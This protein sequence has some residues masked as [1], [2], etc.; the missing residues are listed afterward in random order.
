MQAEF[1]KIN[2][3]NDI[4]S[5][6]REYLSRLSE[7]QELYLEL[8]VKKS[9]CYLI[10][11]TISTIGYAA[12]LD[13]EII[14]EFFVT[15]LFQSVREKVFKSLVDNFGIRKVWCKT[16]DPDLLSC[17]AQYAR[18]IEPLGFLFR[19]YNKRKLE[20]NLPV[21]RIIKAEEYHEESIF[22][23]NEEVFEERVEIMEDIKNGNIFLFMLEREI[24]GFA[25]YHRTI[26]GND[27]F[28]IGILVAKKY[29]RKGFGAFIARYVADYCVQK[30]WRPVCG[31]AYKNEASRRTLEK[32]GFGTRH[33]LLE[34]TVKSG[35]EK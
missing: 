24:I 2:S 16:F 32:A 6:R 27:D 31:C 5:L 17:S 13:G 34:F 33:M 15:P 25:V 35:K 14:T 8:Q 28:D 19:E 22:R 29:R 21:F 30:G 12:V 4:P 9:D 11:S 26:T 20:T 18:A 23:M 10:S 7:P 3:L 1:R